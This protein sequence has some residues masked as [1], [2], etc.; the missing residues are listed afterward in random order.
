MLR[1]IVTSILLVNSIFWGI[2]PPS[3]TS[4]HSKISLQLGLGEVKNRWIHIVIGTIFYIIAVI[5]AQQ[6]YIQHLWC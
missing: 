4:P 5:V 3:D 1:I 2:Y 6:Q